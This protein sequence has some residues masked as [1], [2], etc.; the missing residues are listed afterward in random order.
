MPNESHITHRQKIV[1]A[2]TKVV[3]KGMVEAIVSTESKDRDGDIIRAS[4][5]DLGNFKRHPVLLANHDYA[6]LRSQIGHWEDMGV[7][8]KSL[9]GVAKYYVG[10][11]NDEADW[12][13]KLAEKGR[14]AYSVGFKPDMG[15][16]KELKDS[17]GGFY[18]NYEFLSQE[19]LEVSQVAIPSNPDALQRLKGLHPAV[20]EIVNEVLKDRRPLTGKQVKDFQRTL[21]TA[22][23]RSSR[24]KKVQKA[25]EDVVEEVASELEEVIDAIEELAETVAE[26]TGESDGDAEDSMK[27]P[28]DDED[29]DEDDEDDEEKATFAAGLLSGFRRN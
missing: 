18:A 3:G 15:K 10:E 1:R 16:A 7:K 4:G 25:L 2:T 20:Q 24:L 19:L 22:L 27:A 11:G 6:S 26:M 12:G 13:F 21:K 28:D 14:A 9:V 8:G 23:R 17:E 29:D 5:W